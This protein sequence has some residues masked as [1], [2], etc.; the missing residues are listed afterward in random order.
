[1]PNPHKIASVGGRM[2][3]LAWS[4]DGARLR[5]STNGKLREISAEG[6]NLHELL[7]SWPAAADPCCGSWSPN[8]DIFYFLS[9]GQLWAFDERPGLFGRRSNAPIQL[10]SGPLDWAT[11]VPGKNG[12]K[13]FATGLTRRGELT[14]SIRNPNSSSP[15][16]QASPP[17][18]SP[19]PKMEPTSSTSPTPT[20]ASGAPTATGATG[21]SSSTLR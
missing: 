7:P 3:W 15:T 9:A 10:T 13:L 18:F 20:E 16:C 17:I 21:S 5:F 12:K 14:A 4:P 11:P 19:S 2:E 6:S 1:M 8:G